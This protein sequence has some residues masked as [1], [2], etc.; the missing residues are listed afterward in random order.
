[1][2]SMTDWKAGRGLKI[3]RLYAWIATE[4]DGGEGVVGASM[5]IAGREM[6]VPLIGADGARI[7]SYREY[8]ERTERETGFPVRLVVFG[9][10]RDGEMAGD[11]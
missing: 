11:G 3:E 4:P 7:A 5:M 8:A 2:T 1:M 10:R 6:L 9:D